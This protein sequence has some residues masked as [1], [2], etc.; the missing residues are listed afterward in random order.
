MLFFFIFT[1]VELASLV[2]SLLQYFYQIVEARLKAAELIDFHLT[3]DFVSLAVSFLYSQMEITSET[4]TGSALIRTNC[5]LCQ[6]QDVLIDVEPL[7]FKIVH[8]LIIHS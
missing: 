5:C 7:L 3:L 1:S 4:S 2:L 6:P 8:I